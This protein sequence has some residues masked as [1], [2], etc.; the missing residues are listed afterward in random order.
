[1]YASHFQGKGAL[2][3]LSGQGKDPVRKFQLELRGAIRCEFNK[4]VKRSVLHAPI[5]Y[6][7]NP[8]PKV[9]AHYR[10]FT[11]DA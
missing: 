3:L 2:E 5:H 11:L 9:C 7:S 6:M 10:S 8:S 1:M 4:A